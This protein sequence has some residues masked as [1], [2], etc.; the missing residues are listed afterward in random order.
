MNELDKLK[1]TN[2]ILEKLYKDYITVE[3]GEIIK[4][5]AFEHGW[6]VNEIP[7]EGPVQLPVLGELSFSKDDINVIVKMKN[8]SKNVEENAKTD[9]GFKQL[10]CD[11]E[12]IKEK[13]KSLKN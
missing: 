7:T 6:D 10:S 4:N 1:K 9:S 3:E 13:N 8:F 5:L 12:S 2:K 11:I